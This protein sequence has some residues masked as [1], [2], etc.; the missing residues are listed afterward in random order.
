[1]RTHAYRA[2]A[3]LAGASRGGRHR[4]GGDDTPMERL[5]SSDARRASSQGVMLAALQ[6]SDSMQHPP[7]P[8][9]FGK[10]RVERDQRLRT[11]SVGKLREERLL[12]GEEPL[13]DIPDVLMPDVYQDEQWLEESVGISQ[14]HITDETGALVDWPWEEPKA[15]RTGG[16]R[17]RHRL[18]GV[19]VQGLMSSMASGDMGAKSTGV[20][21]W[22]HFCAAM[23]VTPDRV[24]D[25][26]APLK[27]KLREEWLAMQFI[28]YL[29]EDE[30]LAP[31][32]AATYFGQVQGWHAK[33]HGIKLAAGIK[34]ARLPAML[35]GLRR[36][37]GGE[38]RKVRRGIAPQSLQAALDKCFPDK[39]NIE[40]AN[41]RAALS[42]AFQGLLR[43][44][45]FA[46]DGKFNPKMNLTRA[47][48]VDITAERLV[49]MMRPCKNMQHLS[50]K[51]VPLIIGAG[52]LYVD[53]VAEIRNLI[54]VDPVLRA[55][56]AGTP[57]FR[58][59][60]AD[61]GRVAIS[62]KHVMS[63]TRALMASINEDP[64]QFGT[65][66][67]RIGGATALFAAGA[68]PTVIRTMGRWSSDCYR[69]YVRACFGQTLEWSRRC[70]SQAVSDVAAEFMEV[71]SY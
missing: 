31:S 43:G 41:I 44:A 66:S 7:P 47:D 3:V 27:A 63:V 6:A 51:T 37:R 40:H 17:R 4:D 42:L 14:L 13:P 57:L 10:G 8:S 56:A 2:N 55:D 59:A 18:D 15:R 62:T 60:S 45:E 68:D 21:R 67:Y 20:K 64:S 53:A 5:A 48:L 11:S 25:P 12:E 29:V 49:V 65:H 1:M 35:K 70:G 36:L 39:S 58:Q 33:E 23:G 22:K 69:L 30:G 46:V 28:A 61:G 16:S 52:G 38:V 50:G 26:N 24:L 54:A 19:I 9:I 32:S 34:L 71:D